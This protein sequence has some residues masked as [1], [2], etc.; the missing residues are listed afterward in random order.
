[1]G[2]PLPHDERLGQAIYNMLRPK[3]D[4]EVTS[5]RKMVTDNDVLQYKA[6]IADDLF[7]LEDHKLQRMFFDRFW[8]EK[9]KKGDRL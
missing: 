2:D 5:G 3:D 7:N 1:M 9:C 4:P 6:Q 8:C